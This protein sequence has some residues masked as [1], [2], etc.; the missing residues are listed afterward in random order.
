VTASGTAATASQYISKAIEIIPATT[1][2]R[3]QIKRRLELNRKE[4]MR[5]GTRRL[6]TSF[7]GSVEGM[8]DGKDASALRASL[9]DPSA[10]EVLKN[11]N[12]AASLKAACCD[13]S[14]Q[15]GLN[16]EIPSEPAE[17]K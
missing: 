13:E 17:E 9:Y 7:V 16:V 4:G 1:M 6:G 14:Q 3:R 10:Y 12:T 11:K 15:I 5:L 2:D 8:M